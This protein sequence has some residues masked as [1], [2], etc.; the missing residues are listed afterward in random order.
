MDDFAG[1]LSMVYKPQS[2]RRIRS[3][4]HRRLVSALYKAGS[5][6]LLPEPLKLGRGNAIKEDIIPARR[7]SQSGSKLRSFIVADLRDNSY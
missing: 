1:Y 2:K 4:I 7:P 6:A 3:R 5:E